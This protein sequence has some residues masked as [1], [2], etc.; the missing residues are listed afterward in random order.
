[1]DEDYPRQAGSRIGVLFAGLILGALIMTA[2]WVAVGGNPLS[3]VNE[4]VYQQ[5]TVAD[6]TEDSICWSQDPG[7]RDAARQCAILAIDPAVEPPRPGDVVVA[8]V[9]T[10][11]PQRGDE[12]TQVVYIE[13]SGGEPDVE[14]TPS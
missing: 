2:V 13:P 10:L 1:M 9:T 6:V 3:D 5:I 14:P 8:G 11:H 7:R 12:R 4:V